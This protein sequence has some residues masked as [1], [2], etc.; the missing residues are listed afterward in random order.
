MKL[1]KKFIVNGLFILSAFFSVMYLFEMIMNTV[2]FF[3]GVGYTY[4]LSGYYSG[5]YS[6]TIKYLCLIST[7]ALIAI[8]I[9]DAFLS[10]KHTSKKLRIIFICIAILC[11]LA[12]LVSII[13]AATSVSNTKGSNNNLFYD[14]FSGTLIS[15]I[16][17]SGILTAI[18]I[19]LSKYKKAEE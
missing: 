7:I 16:V 2:N 14:S 13:V 6:N 4:I 17:S 9:L 18:S 10:F 8:I 19:Y 1:D 15:T 11:I 12:I 3:S 5:Y